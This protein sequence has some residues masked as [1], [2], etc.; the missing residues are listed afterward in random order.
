VGIVQQDINLFSGT[1]LDN[2]RFF[3][4]DVPQERVIDVCILIGADTFIR[5]LPD[6][7]NTLLSEKGATLS[8][9]ERQLLSF[10]R[11]MVF[12]PKMLILDEATASLDSDSEAVLQQAISKVSTGRTL[13][14]IAHRLSTVQQMDYIIVL[15]NGKIVEKGSH[16][17]L[18]MNKG[19]YSILHT[20]GILVKEA[21]I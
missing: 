19:Y 10:A 8:F 21:I 9:G 12:N 2:I 14:V 16:D 17:T 15:D 20:S 13:L 18:L 3:R 5:K 6:G 1:V 4:K 7:Y 11:V